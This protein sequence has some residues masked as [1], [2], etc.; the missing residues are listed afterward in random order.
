MK[1]IVFDLDN[2]LIDFL[3]MKRICCTAAVEAMIGSGLKLVH[4][5]KIMLEAKN[6]KEIIVISL[7]ILI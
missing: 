7:I 4:P 1:A 2:T 3:K 6:K 5:I